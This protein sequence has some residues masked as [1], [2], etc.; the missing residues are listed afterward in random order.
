LCERGIQSVSER[1]R[2]KERKQR[3]KERVIA[4]ERRRERG[5]AKERRRQSERE[6]A[7]ERERYSVLKLNIIFVCSQ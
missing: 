1:G 6:K 3:K 5:I 2:S 4:N 7:K